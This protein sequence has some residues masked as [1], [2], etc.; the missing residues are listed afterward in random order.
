MRFGYMCPY[1]KLGCGESEARERIKYCLRKLGHEVVELDNYNYSFSDGIYAE[2]LK[3]DCLLSHCVVEQ[4]DRV[5]PDIFSCFFYW[6]PSEFLSP[7][8]AVDYITYMNKHDIIVGGYESNFTKL[9]LSNTRFFECNQDLLKFSASIPLDWIIPPQNNIN[10]KLFYVGM[11]VGLKSRYIDL[12]RFLDSKNL[13]N[14]Y[15]PLMAFGKKNTYSNLTSYKGDIPFDGRTILK[16]INQAGICLALNSNIHNSVDFVSNRIY[17]AAAAGAIIISDDNLYVRKYFGDSVFYIDTTLP[18]S[19]QIEKIK[20]IL[21]F[22]KNN[23]EFVYKMAVESQRIFKEKLAMEQQVIDLVDFIKQ[24]KVEMETQNNFGV[25]VICE[26]DSIDD[27]N[28]IYK[29]LKKQYVK[30][31]R[32]ILITSIDIFEK[33]N[34][35]IDLEMFFIL[36]QEHNG[37]NYLEAI[38]NVKSKYFFFMNKYS[39]LHANHVLKNI[40]ALDDNVLFSYSGTYLKQKDGYITLNNKPISQ[41]LFLNLINKNVELSFGVEETTSLSSVIFKTSVL[42]FVNNYEM[43]QINSSP[44]MY[45]ILCSI[46]KANKTGQFTYCLSS[47]YKDI[48]DIEK[49]FLNQRKIYTEEKR[50]KNLL[51]YELRKVFIKYNIEFLAENDLSDNIAKEIYIVI[52]NKIKL[53]KLF[54]KLKKLFTCNKEKRKKINMKIIECKELIQKLKYKM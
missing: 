12:I 22:I 2:N 46:I 49:L 3:L 7:D 17:E 48:E 8:I 50:A 36:K 1:N 33:I 24:K 53:K 4:C 45:L 35:S 40:K 54:L 37:V 30:N 41:N 43:M 34:N 23:Q 16:K 47:G 19:M 52:K 26:L 27:F 15:G 25:D 5:F 14:I 6:C 10:Y 44:H 32:L 20:E 51:Q 28:T 39:H 13:I 9:N 21:D 38:K 11:N 31:Y 29:E 18:E 42:D